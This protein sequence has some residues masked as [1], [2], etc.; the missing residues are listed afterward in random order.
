MRPAVQLLIAWS[1]EE[2]RLLAVLNWSRSEQLDLRAFVL[3]VGSV[4]PLFVSVSL[5]SVA[6]I[7]QT[8]VWRCLP[9]VVVLA[10]C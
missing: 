1:T 4:N 5:K 9:A 2:W 10:P 7:A 8:A 3:L 6:S